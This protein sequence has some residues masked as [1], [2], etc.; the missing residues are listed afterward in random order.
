[1]RTA[2][3]V[4][5]NRERAISR[6]SK[7]E[8]PTLTTVITIMTSL[9]EPP[10][11]AEGAID[12]LC[13][14]YPYIRDPNDVIWMKDVDQITLVLDKDHEL[15]KISHAM[16]ESLTSG[17][18]HTDD[19]PPSVQFLPRKQQLV[20][21]I[22]RN[23]V[24]RDESLG[25]RERLLGLALLWS[26]AD[27]FGLWAIHEDLLHDEAMMF[28]Q[29]GKANILKWKRSVLYSDGRRNYKVDSVHEIDADNR[30]VVI[31]FDCLLPG[32]EGRGTEVIRF[33]EDWSVI[34]VQSIRHEC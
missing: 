12:R 16:E 24:L 10:A 21:K 34:R 31:G 19:L 8:D 15:S 33:S 6:R 2:D 22:L 23:K 25:D 5:A 17:T 7:I 28:G 32:K 13:F 9:P 30:A 11:P 20:L 1:M 14:A 4:R 3:R 18:L 26:F 27:A 29:C